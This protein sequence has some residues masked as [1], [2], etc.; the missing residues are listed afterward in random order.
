VIC[1]ENGSSGAVRLIR[2]RAHFLP[3]FRCRRERAGGHALEGRVLRRG[4]DRRGTGGRGGTP[5][6]STRKFTVALKTKNNPTKNT[7]KTAKKHENHARLGKAVFR[8]KTRKITD[9]RRKNTKNTRKSWIFRGCARNTAFNSLG[10]NHY[11]PSCIIRNS[12]LFKATYTKRPTER[13]H[14]ER[15]PFSASS[16]GYPSF[17]IIYCQLGRARVFSFS[18]VKRM[19]A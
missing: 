5:V 10:G 14:I 7:R 19:K 3:R 1:S 12:I 9:F 6:W 8:A 16:V 17:V 15:N 4:T 18:R 13:I 2:R 11:L